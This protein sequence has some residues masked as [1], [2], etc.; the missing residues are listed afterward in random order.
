MILMELLLQLTHAVCRQITV[1][2]FRSWFGLGIDVVP[3]QGFY[4]CLMI[5]T[6]SMHIYFDVRIIR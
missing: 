4:R 3:R 2:I 5:D 1:F 6:S